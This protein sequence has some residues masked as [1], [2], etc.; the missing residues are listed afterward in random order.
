MRRLIPML[1]LLTTACASTPE[2]RPPKPTEPAPAAAPTMPAPT[3]TLP[4]PP[5][6]FLTW[7]SVLVVSDHLEDRWL[8]GPPVRGDDDSFQAERTLKDSPELRASRAFVGGE[9]RV[10]ALGPGTD[11]RIRI[12]SLVGLS[13]A[14]PESDDLSVMYPNTDEHPEP[15]DEERSQMLWTLGRKALAAH[16]E[17][18]GEPCERPFLAAPA[19]TFPSELAH[20]EYEQTKPAPALLAR[21]VELAKQHALWQEQEDVYQATT[22]L[23]KAHRRALSAAGYDVDLKKPFPKHWDEARRGAEY[24]RP[25]L[26]TWRDRSGQAL[27]HMLTIGNDLACGAPRAWLLFDGELTTVLRY[28]VDWSPDAILDLDGDGT[29]ELAR[30]NGLVS[31]IEALDPAG[32][33]TPRVYRD[34]GVLPPAPILDCAWEQVPPPAEIEEALHPKPK[35]DEAP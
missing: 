35:T 14:D 9:M 12:T 30:E 24:G 32:R 5:W 22:A 7:G 34:N 4:A 17:W 18:I 10:L 6:L 2:T 11:C 29:W 8:D 31:Y 15:T 16:F 3:P 28:G 13:W 20:D 21:A 23:A 26:E 27:F 33:D 25:E 19:Q 1:A